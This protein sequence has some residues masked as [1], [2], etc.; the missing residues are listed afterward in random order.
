MI[1]HLSDG[2]AFPRRRF[3]RFSLVESTRGRLA[4]LKLPWGAMSLLL[5]RMR[6]L[7]VISDAAF[8]RGM[9]EMSRRGWRGLSRL[10]LVSPNNRSC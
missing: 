2:T 4:E 3:F 7:G 1:C 6:D 8:R 10:L 9:M 5:R